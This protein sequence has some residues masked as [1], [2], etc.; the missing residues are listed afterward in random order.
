MVRGIEQVPAFDDAGQDPLLMVLISFVIS[1]VFGIISAIIIGR[2]LTTP[3][4]ALGHT[5]RSSTAETP[6]HFPKTHITEIDS[7]ADAVQILNRDVERTASR[8][9]CV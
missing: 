6:L 4:A 3:I 9:R 8:F 5:L 2:I 7:L 1:I